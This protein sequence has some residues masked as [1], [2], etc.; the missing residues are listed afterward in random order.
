MSDSV[1]RDILGVLTEIRDELRASNEP[2]QATLMGL[3]GF[4]PPYRRAPQPSEMPA[5]E[6]D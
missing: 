6:H 5:L 1:M 4:E 3:Q 2:R